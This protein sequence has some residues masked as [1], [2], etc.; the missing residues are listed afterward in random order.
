MAKREEGLFD[1]TT[2]RLYAGRKSVEGNNSFLA[3]KKKTLSV[4]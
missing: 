1:L 4:I 2:L 3:C